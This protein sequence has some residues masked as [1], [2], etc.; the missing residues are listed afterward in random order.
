MKIIICGAGI[1]GRGIA[2]ELCQENHNV[3]VIDNDKENID[4]LRDNFEVVTVLGYPSHPDSLKKAGA[5]N[6]DILIAVTPSDE[7][8]MLTCQVAHSMFGVEK[9]IARVRTQAYLGKNFNKIYNGENVAIDYVISPE[10]EVAEAI[11]SRLETPGAIDSFSIADGN[12]SVLEL[13]ASNDNIVGRYLVNLERDYDVRVFG[14]VREGKFLMP[15]LDFEFKEA[16]EIFLVT[17]TKSL[18]KVLKQL[19]HKE[20]RNDKL[21][22]V[23]GGNIGYFVAKAIEKA[24][25]SIDVSMVELGIERAN[26]LATNLEDADIINGNALDEVILNESGLQGAES[27]ICVTHDDK[28]NIFSAILAKKL[29]PNIKSLCLIN[30]I[31]S[32][33]SIVSS[34]GIDSVIDPREMTLSSILTSLRTGLVQSDRS[35]CYGQAEVVELEIEE[36]NKLIGRTAQDIETDGKIRLATIY[37]DGQMLNRDEET[38][39]HQGDII[40]LVALTEN[41]SNIEKLC[42]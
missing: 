26:F 5:D 11:I 12:L 7:I 30:R 22:I 4:L 39:I 24:G 14:A 31:D 19:G 23:G 20:K 25:S 27:I 29:N 38:T 15:S 1:V 41:I 21:I 2:K 17:K 13:R 36:E 3:I 6:A 8:N 37:R 42:A 18:D 33:G 32:Y 16:D 40:A 34:L 10:K 35:I 28:V 9:K